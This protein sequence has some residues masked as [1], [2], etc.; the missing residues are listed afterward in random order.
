MILLA[1]LAIIAGAIYAIVR[2]VDVRLALLLASLALGILGGDPM[3]IVRKFLIT[4]ADEQ[5]VVPICCAMGF[6][7]VLRH[8]EC[9]Q[10]LVHLLVEP[11]TRVRGF[12]IPGA[13]LVG[14]LVNIPIVSQTSTAV[15]IGAVLIPLLL[16]ARISP[17]TVG[18]ALLLGSS[19]GGELLN[20]GA[21][22]LQTT[23]KETRRVAEVNAKPSSAHPGGSKSKPPETRQREGVSVTGEQCV[24]RIV[25]LV[26]VQLAVATLLFWIG[27]IRYEARL[28]RGLTE[29]A[30]KN[31][32]EEVGAFKV[33]LFKA[34][35]PLVPLVLLFLVAHPFKVFELPP[36]WL[37]GDR[38]KKD[39]EIHF[40]SRLIGAAMLVGVVVAAVSALEKAPG[41]AR[42]FFDGAGY[43]FTN[44]ISLI[45]IA[46]CLGEGVKLIGLARLIG[47]LIG[48]VP[49]LLFPFAGSLPLGFAWVCGSG[50]ASTQSLFGFFA[51]PA[52]DL[53][54]DPAHVGAVVSIASAAGRTMSPVAAVTLMCAS[55]TQTSPIELVKRVALPLLV[56]IVLTVLA[57][58]LMATLTTLVSTG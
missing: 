10:H 48:E 57:A 13:V 21:P 37:L 20:P 6:A 9:D 11:L 46:S 33:N 26:L 8:T 42:A 43:A 53:D 40:D 28:G 54:I 30:G 25:P 39:E 50:M 52:L 15:T 51:Q 27:S 44:I 7:Y 1:G 35:V 3:A 31:A 22:E 5:F 12:L 23:V 16:G 41:V 36:E 17:V 32:A 45:V 49:G 29:H 58:A 4:L 24:G 18:A 2:R 56:A 14:F 34:F 55:M 47:E 19:L 38:Y